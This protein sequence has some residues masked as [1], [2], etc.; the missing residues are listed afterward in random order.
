M[1]MVDLLET[2]ERLPKA[3]INALNQFERDSDSG[4]SYKA[5]ESLSYALERLGY[6]FDYDLDG[7]PYDLREEQKQ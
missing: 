4:C 1:S 6:K 5:C 3:V 7:E 2:P